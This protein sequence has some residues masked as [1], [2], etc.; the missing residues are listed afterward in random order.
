MTLFTPFGGGLSR[1]RVR[2]T[3]FGVERVSFSS[4]FNFQGLLAGI[5]AMFSGVVWFGGFLVAVLP[6][7]VVSCLVSPFTCPLFLPGSV[8]SW[9]VMWV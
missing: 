9:C 7:L 6:C 2:T 1:A 4:A 5:A 8:L 3:S